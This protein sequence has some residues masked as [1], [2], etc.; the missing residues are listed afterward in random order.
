MRTVVVA[1]KK[2]GAGKSTISANMAGA[3]GDLDLNVLYIDTDPQGTG[4]K[5]LGDINPTGTGLVEFI[6][7][8]DTSSISTTKISET[9]NGQ[10]DFIANNDPN[11][12]LRLFF[13]QTTS[14]VFYFAHAI[15]KIEQNY[16]VVIIDTKGDDGRGEVKESAVLAGDIIL[17]PTRPAGL[18]V[19]EIEHNIEI[20]NKITQPFSSMGLTRSEPVLKILINAAKRTNLSKDVSKFLRE[21]YN[22]ENVPVSV[23]ATEIPN[24]DVYESYVTSGDFVHRLDNKPRPGLNPAPSAAQSMLSLIH[25]LFPNFI[26]LHF[27]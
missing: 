18:D 9:L 16:D 7:N 1:N 10:V 14:H 21:N 2:G 24:L 19:A 5:L 8:Q 4:S 23:L 26:D 17:T 25:E 3:L 13:Q 20:F 22:S 27:S 11:N 15:K 6:I 12:E